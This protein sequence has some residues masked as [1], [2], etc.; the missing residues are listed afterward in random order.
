[1]YSGSELTLHSPLSLLALVL[2]GCWNAILGWLPRVRHAAEGREHYDLTHHIAVVTG[3][4]TGIGK[5]TALS[6]A[7]YGGTVILA[8]RD[9]SKGIAAANDINRELASL[10][11]SDSEYSF[12]HSAHGRALYM[13]LDLADEL[14]ILEFSRKVKDD[15]P[16]IDILINNAGLNSK[17]V[18]RNGVQQLF[19]VNYLGHYLLLR[20]LESHLASRRY[21]TTSHASPAPLVARVINLSSVMHHVGKYVTSSTAAC[22][23]I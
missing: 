20:C 11:G 14:S 10:V 9:S 6:L 12:P 18:L 21:T 7:K 16:R 22:L 8:C 23:H 2:G 19:Q 4:N 13:K 5:E 17:G 3:S 1:M 15:F